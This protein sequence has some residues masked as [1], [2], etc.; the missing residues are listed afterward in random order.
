MIFSELR[1]NLPYPNTGLTTQMLQE[2]TGQVHKERAGTGELKG[3]VDDDVSVG[4][5]GTWRRI[6]SDFS[7][8]SQVGWLVFM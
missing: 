4:D 8:R 7:R 3:T 2:Q 5:C 1:V 6:I